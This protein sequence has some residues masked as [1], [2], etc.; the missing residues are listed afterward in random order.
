[1]HEKL[2]LVLSD[3]SMSR[4]LAQ[5]EIMRVRKREAEQDL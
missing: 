4:P 3:S 2:L 5:H 1:M